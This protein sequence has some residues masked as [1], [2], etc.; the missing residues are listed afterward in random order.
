[1]DAGIDADG[2]AVTVLLPV[3]NR[4]AALGEAARSIL[5]QRFTD[6]E[7]LIVDD[8]SDDET[9]EV[10]AALAE[11]DLR[12]RVIRQ[13][14][15]GLVAALNRGI[16]EAR[17]PLIA[18]MNADDVAYPERLELQVAVMRRRPSLAL[19]GSGWRVIG[20][21][22]VVRRVVLPPET[23]AGLRVAMGSGNALAHPTVMIRREAVLR[24]G[25]Y[26]PDFVAAEDVDLW[27]RLLDRYEAA[28]L[29]EVVLDHLEQ[30]G[31]LTWRALEQRIL[32][33]MGALA[34]ADCRQVGRPDFGD[35]A[36][37]VDR[38]RLLR[39]GMTADE[40]AAGMIARAFAAAQ[41]AREARQAALLG[42]RQPGLTLRERA[43]F[44]L[45]LL[46]AMTGLELRSRRSMA[47][48]LE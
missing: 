31:R 48:K 40:I 6:F 23:D 21:G 2:P 39:M 4:A 44:A 18:R 8:G 37:P 36:R 24:V 30:P 10:A 1:M 17:S 15:L 29:P 11:K 14:R 5:L 20:A 9:G 12:V 27:L 13:E 35:E 3:R 41:D 33:E 22:G 32:S 34:A 19:L 43:H 26:R 28:C 7:L 42:L 47:W 25:G 16:G 45:L 38:A 46:Q